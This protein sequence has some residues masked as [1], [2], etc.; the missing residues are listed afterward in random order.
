ML[1]TTV[2]SVGLLIILVGVIP[3]CFYFT[4]F[5][6]INSKWFLNKYIEVKEDKKFIKN[7]QIVVLICFGFPFVYGNMLWLLSWIYNILK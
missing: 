3:F 7:T 4:F 5:K 2:Q 1:L 6:I